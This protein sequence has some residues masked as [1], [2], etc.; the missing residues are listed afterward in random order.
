V[1][2]WRKVHYRTIQRKIL[3]VALLF[4]VIVTATNERRGALLDHQD[5]RK[6]LESGVGR[7][8][9]GSR[10]Q[11]KTAGG[12]GTG[13]GRRHRPAVGSARDSGRAVDP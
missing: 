9:Y 11:C 13:V 8:G 5:S 2:A 7:L 1:A 10:R 3:T 12:V 4:Y 6:G